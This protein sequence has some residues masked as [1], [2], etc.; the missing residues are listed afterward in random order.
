MLT[1]GGHVSSSHLPV[2][3]LNRLK[4]GVMRSFPYPD[5]FSVF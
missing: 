1:S 3:L 4:A 2:G 5:K